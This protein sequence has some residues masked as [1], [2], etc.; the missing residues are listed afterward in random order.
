VCG[1]CTCVPQLRVVTQED[2]KF[3]RFRR[4]EV[5]VFELKEMI[6]T[7]AAKIDD[8]TNK[9]ATNTEAM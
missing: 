4:D 7:N 3:Q 8:N 1:V 5:G 9:I 2:V 6:E